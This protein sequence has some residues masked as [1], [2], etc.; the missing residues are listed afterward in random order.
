MT[1]DVTIIREN[2]HTGRFKKTAYEVFTREEAINN[3]IKFKFWRDETVEVG[4]KVLTDD[5]YVVDVLNVRKRNYRPIGYRNMIVRTPFATVYAD[6]LFKNQLL[7]EED[8]RRLFLNRNRSN[9][10]GLSSLTAKQLVFALYVSAGASIDVAYMRSYNCFS[11]I[12][13][14]KEGKRLLRKKKVQEQIVNNSK[15]IFE[16]H[17]LTPDFIVRKIVEQIDDPS[18]IVRK[19][20]IRLAADLIGLRRLGYKTMS[21][22]QIGD[23]EREFENVK[24]SEEFKEDFNVVQF[25]KVNT[26]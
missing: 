12:T 1:F 10:E 22:P 13:A 2:K 4:E 19:D 17:G 20:A 24:P 9:Y 26:N 15:N 21:G 16:E 25:G 23:V 18:P 11:S 6:K 14:L 5:G 7:C 8:Y 3:N